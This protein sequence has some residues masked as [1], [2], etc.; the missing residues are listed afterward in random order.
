MFFR[1]TKGASYYSLIN[2][3]LHRSQHPP[4]VALSM[5]KISPKLCDKLNEL[6]H[7]PF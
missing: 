1:S 6:A 5:W 3:V 2:A 4:D 7:L